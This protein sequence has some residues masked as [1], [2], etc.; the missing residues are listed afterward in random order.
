M[1]DRGWTTSSI[2]Y[3]GHG[4]LNNNGVTHAPFV[5][6]ARARP[7]VASSTKLA[8]TGGRRAAI[9]A[10]EGIRGGACGY[11]GL[12]R[13]AAACHRQQLELLPCLASSLSQVSS[14]HCAEMA[15]GALSRGQ[16]EATHHPSL[17]PPGRSTQPTNPHTLCLYTANH[18]DYT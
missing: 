16:E 3:I 17:P 13:G 10:A 11:L 4:Q 9:A 14:K 2:I 1:Q 15:W 7:P 6:R 12:Q 18:G 5:E 8:A